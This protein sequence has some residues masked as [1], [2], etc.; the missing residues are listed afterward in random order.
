ML[1]LFFIFYNAI[2]DRYDDS[3]ICRF[4]SVFH[5]CYNEWYLVSP[6]TSVLVSVRHIRS[7]FV[8]NFFS[9]L[10]VL[11][12]FN[13]TFIK[14]IH[15]PS[16][17]VLHRF[18]NLTYDRSCYLYKNM[19]SKDIYIELTWQTLGKTSFSNYVLTRC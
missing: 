16:L 11:L 18:I 15:H 8:K 6:K 3:T 10:I 4:L 2:P 17:T 19:T 14:K 5:K 12:S 13:T 7:Y 1:Y 9:F